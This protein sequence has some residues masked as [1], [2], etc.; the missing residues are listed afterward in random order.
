MTRGRVPAK[1]VDFP[2]TPTTS[3]ARVAAGLA[4]LVPARM[5]SIRAYGGN[6]AMG[7]SCD[8]TGM[9]LIGKDAGVVFKG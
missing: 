6:V 3:T 1:L 2:G 4:L 8:L 9:S 7:W 5:P